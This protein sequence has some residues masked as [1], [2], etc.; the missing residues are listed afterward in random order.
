M[1]GLDNIVAGA[2]NV[3]TIWKLPR[4]TALE[5]KALLSRFYHS[6]SGRVTFACKLCKVELIFFIVI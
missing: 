3:D 1:T 5:D 6:F 4:H 2:V